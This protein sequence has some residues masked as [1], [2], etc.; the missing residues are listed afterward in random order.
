MFCKNSLEEGAVF[1]VCFSCGCKIWGEKMYRAIKKSMEDAHE[2]GNLH[3]GSISE[4]KHKFESELSRT[5]RD[6]LRDINRPFSEF[7]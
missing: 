6:G 7:N 5:S 1:D 3:Q 4:P 2:T